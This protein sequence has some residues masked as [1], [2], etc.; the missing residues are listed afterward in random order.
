MFCRSPLIIVAVCVLVLAGC[1]GTSQIA[2]E[3]P[4]QYNPRQATCLL[5][6]AVYEHI[7]KPV[8]GI[9]NT[10]VETMLGMSLDRDAVAVSYCRQKAQ[11]LE[12]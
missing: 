10:S 6:Y 8:F 2:G 3:P 1:T 9:I 7:A 4:D 12:Q 5:R 11:V